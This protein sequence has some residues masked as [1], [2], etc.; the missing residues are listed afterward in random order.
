MPATQEKDL[1]KQMEQYPIVTFA[2]ILRALKSHPEWLEE[3][4]KIILTTELLELPKK[5]DELLKRV[6]K[7][8]S[9]VEILKQDVAILKQDVAI[10]KQD[11]AVLKQDVA[12]LKQDVEILKKDVAYLKGEFGR[13]K[14]KDFERTIREKY[15][16]YFGKLLRK[17]KLIQFEEILP[18]L[19]DAEEKGL[20]TEEQRDSLLRLDII[21]KGQIKSTQKPVVLAV[22]VSYSLYK[23][24]IERAIERAEI[25][26]QL[27]KEEV[28]PTVVSAETQEDAEK[29]ADEKGVLLIKTDY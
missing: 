27:L 24:D 16:A 23:D 22:E 17:T 10:L 13:F 20:I 15:Y 19:D 25:L 8:E 7:I 21:V 12:I 28:I 9:D 26:A 11:V 4:R 2:D 14:G 6:E 1:E 3:L 29:L 5:F 18:I